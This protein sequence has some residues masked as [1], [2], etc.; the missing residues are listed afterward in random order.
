MLLPLISLP[1]VPW[2]TTSQIEYQNTSDWLIWVNNERH[3]EITS[4]G[5]WHGL[6]SEL[7]WRRE[8]WFLAFAYQNAPSMRVTST[9]HLTAHIREGWRLG[10]LEGLRPPHTPALPA[11]FRPE[12]QR[13]RPAG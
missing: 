5:H 3:S 8:Y 11:V 10:Y 13:A 2:E 9:Y 1:W 7:T 12:P 4:D 6:A